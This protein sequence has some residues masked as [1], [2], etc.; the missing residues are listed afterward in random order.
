MGVRRLHERGSE[1]IP[2]ERI[3]SGGFDGT[4]G[5]HGQRGQRNPLVLELCHWCAPPAP[6]G[7]SWTEPTPGN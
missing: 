2:Y 4:A 3:G 1:R 7:F 5:S 6:G